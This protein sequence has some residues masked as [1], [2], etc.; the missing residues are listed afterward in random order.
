MITSMSPL[1]RLVLQQPLRPLK[2]AEFEELVRQGFFEDE[3]VELLF[4]HLVTMSP[5]GNSH[6]YVMRRLNELFILALA[7]RASV[8][9]QGSY[10]ASDESEPEPDLAIIPRDLGPNDYPSNAHLLVEV[11]V[12]SQAKDRRIKRVLYARAGV[13]EYWLVD[14]PAATV[15][16][17]REP[18]DGDYR[19]VTT[20]G[21]SD[22][23][24]PLAFPDVAIRVAEFLP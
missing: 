18:V 2:R 19:S 14:V 20:V 16:I 10:A 11:S 21:K 12:T 9:P 8:Q 22:T 24:S 13:P 5:Q 3:K 6:M 1:E 23:I 15:E 17:Y 7:G 4:G